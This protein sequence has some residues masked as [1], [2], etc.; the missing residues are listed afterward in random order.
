MEPDDAERRRGEPHQ[1]DERARSLVTPRRVVG[2]IFLAL[3]L[4]FLV[5]N[6]ASAHMHFLGLSFSL[7][8]GVALVISAVA[9][10]VLALVA[11]AAGRRR[12]RA[13]NRHH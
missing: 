10:A 3:V 4:T 5:Q 8:L 2:A 9:G 13:R 12:A 6:G 11:T 1:R 7:P